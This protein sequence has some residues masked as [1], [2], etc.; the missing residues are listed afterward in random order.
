MSTH[1]RKQTKVK[2]MESQEELESHR[3]TGVF[4]IQSAYNGCTKISGRWLGVVDDEELSVLAPCIEL[5]GGQ[6]LLLDPLYIVTLDGTETEIY[7]PRHWQSFYGGSRLP[8]VF[9]WLLEHQK[10]G[11][12]ETVGLH[13]PMYEKG[14]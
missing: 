4:H 9:D 3:V 5:E 7:N 6:L 8:W 1:N 13:H 14:K 11:L 10:W 12:P 2:E